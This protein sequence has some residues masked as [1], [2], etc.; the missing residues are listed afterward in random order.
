MLA[1]GHARRRRAARRAR[2]PSAALAPL[3]RGAR[4]RA[5][6]EVARG[7]LRIAAADMADAIREITVEQGQDPR[8]RGADAVRRRRPAVR[9]RCSPASSASTRIVVPPHAGNFSAWGLLGADLVQT[10]ARTRIIASTDGRPRG[11]NAIA[12]RAVRRRRRAA[13]RTTAPCARSPLDLRYVGPGAHAHGRGAA[14][15]DG[16]IDAVAA[17]TLDDQFRA[18]YER[19]FGCAGRGGRDRLGARDRAHAAAAAAARR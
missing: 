16:R 13:P 3:A 8:R 17:E 2:P 4:L 19:T 12:R 1:E 9:R 18:E 11:A 7:I 10:A 14:G 6:S 15:G 5:P